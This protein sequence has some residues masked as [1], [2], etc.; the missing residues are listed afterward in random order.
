MIRLDEIDPAVRTIVHTVAGRAMTDGAQAVVLTGSQVGQTPSPESDIDIIVIGSGP[1]Y[2]LEIVD[3]RLVSLSWRDLDELRASFDDPSAVGTLVP[4]WR[5][6]IIVTDPQQ[7]AAGLHR[8]ALDWDWAIIG[9]ERLDAWVAEEITGYAE[10]IHK[11]TAA[12]RSGDLATAAAQRSILAIALAP[13]LAVHLRM[14]YGTE[15]GLWERVA[16]RV[17]EEW[18]AAQRA[19]LGLGGEDLAAS[20]DAAMNL[21]RL[22]VV[23]TW[24]TMDARQKAVCSGALEIAGL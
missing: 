16:E 22:A 13:R 9:D 10:E 7:V 4:G 19:A 3:S 14:L 5:R 21:F 6:V 24:P 15:N 18:S 1:R 8:T 17:G 11:L 23:A 2:R 20:I 12:R